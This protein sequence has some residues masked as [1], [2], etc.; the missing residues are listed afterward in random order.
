MYRKTQAKFNIFCF[1]RIFSFLFFSKFFSDFFFSKKIFSWNFWENHFWQKSLGKKSE[2][3][4]VK[5]NRKKSLKKTKMKKC[6]QNK[7]VKFGLGFTVHLKSLTPPPQKR[8]GGIG[9]LTLDYGKHFTKILS[10]FVST[11]VYVEQSI[12][13]AHTNRTETFTI[14]WKNIFFLFF[15]GEYNGTKN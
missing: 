9:Q 6:G 14:I 12:C 13:I 10:L 8:E 11:V 1:A 15:Y 3:K 4:F 2:K 5:K 7:N